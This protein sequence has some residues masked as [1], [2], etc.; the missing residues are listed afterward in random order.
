MTETMV[1]KVR[2]VADRCK[3]TNRTVID[4]VHKGWLQ[5]VRLPSGQLRITDE[6]FQKLTRPVPEKQAK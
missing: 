6:S 2:A 5:A 3:V 1:H 4:W